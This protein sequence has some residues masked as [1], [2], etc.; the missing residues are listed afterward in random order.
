MKKTR[1]GIVGCG[2]I[3]SSLARSVVRDFS[4]NSALSALCDVDA[5]KAID[6]SRKLGKKIPVVSLARL[7]NMSDLVIESAH[8]RFSA[9]IARAALKKKRDVMVMSVGGLVGK[10]D[11]IKSLAL[12]AGSKVYIPSGAI[13]GI[14]AVKAASMGKIRTATLTTTKNPRAFKGVRYVEAKFPLLDKIKK[15]VVLFCGPAKE[16]VKYFPQNINVAAVL[17]LAGIGAG[18]TIV[19]I[20]A[21]QAVNKNIHEVSVEA[22]AGNIATRTENILHPENPKTSFLAVLSA[23]AVLKQILEP[24]KIG[25]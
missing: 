2:A 17:S 18:K 5:G 8:A 15:P 14:D 19:R 24:V 13:S 22:Q 20:I 23:Q 9:Q 7:I 3:G 6:L 25:T 1:I 16:A 4:R 12:K 11:K 10:I 21:S